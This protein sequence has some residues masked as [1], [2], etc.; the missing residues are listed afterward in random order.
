MILSKQTYSEF[1]YICMFAT[2]CVLCLMIVYISLTTVPAALHFV[3][4]QPFENACVTMGS[5]FVCV[6]VCACACVSLSLSLSPSG[7]PSRGYLGAGHGGG[8]PVAPIGAVGAQL[9][10]Q[11]AGLAPEVRPQHQEPQRPRAAGPATD[12]RPPAGEQGLAS[13]ELQQ[14]GRHAT[15]HARTHTHRPTL[16]AD[17]IGQPMYRSG[18][19]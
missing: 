7:G 1:R 2:G 9:P 15:T 5:V 14:V 13:Q 8:K 10:V 3:V 18:S 4:P 11:P 16:S 17:R 19:R 6:C 12:H